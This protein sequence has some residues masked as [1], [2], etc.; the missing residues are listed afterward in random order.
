MNIELA[1]VS[2]PDFGMPQAEPV[3]QKPI[4]DRRIESL[5]KLMQ[6]KQLDVVVVYG[7]KEHNANTTY[8]SGYDPRF[9]ESILIV[10][11][12]GLPALLIGNE[13]GP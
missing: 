10:G 5:R 3:L 1:K 8:L 12:D 7:D 6:Q 13:V 2:L 9:E 11:K 4:Y